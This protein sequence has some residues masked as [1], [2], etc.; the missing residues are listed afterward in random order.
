[1]EAPKVHD[2]EGIM[3]RAKYYIASNVRQMPLCG[4][5]PESDM[6]YREPYG[7]D[8]WRREM[9]NDSLHEEQIIVGY[10]QQ[11]PY[12]TGNGQNQNFHQNYGI[13]GFAQRN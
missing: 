1:L 7:E 5:N 13:S 10:G 3:G 6:V 12:G 4:L 9:E 2:I 11:P 8:Y